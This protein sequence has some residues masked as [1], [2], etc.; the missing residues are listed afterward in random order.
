MN[1]QRAALGLCLVWLSACG[2]LGPRIETP[3]LQVVHIDVLHSDLMQQQLRVRLSVRNPN[4]RVLQVRGI[5]Y[6]M[7]VA[8]ETFANGES[9][10]DFEV[11]AQ[12][13]TEFDVSMTANAAGT[14]LRL[15]ASGHKL[16]KVD[17]RLVGEVSLAKGLLR[18]IPFEEKGQFKLR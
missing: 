9:Q 1:W 17:Y 5:T 10:R 14:L 3:K 6:R 7:E 4:D 11:P 12:G 2:V 18:K 13:T 15:I 16:D 8:G